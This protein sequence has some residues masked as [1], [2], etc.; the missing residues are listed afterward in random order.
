MSNSDHALPHNWR[1]SIAANGTPGTNSPVTTFTGT[2]DEDLD[3]SAF[4]EYA[5]GT[6]DNT[7]DSSP[8]ALNEGTLS[9]SRSLAAHDLRLIVE[10][11]TD[12][13]PG[14]IIEGESL[15]V[16]KSD[17]PAQPQVMT[18]FAT[19]LWSGN[20]QLWWIAGKKGATLTA[21]FIVPTAGDFNIHF[22]ATKAIDYGIH[23][24]TINGTSLGAA[25][26]FYQS[27]AK[28]VSHTG[29]VSLGKA[30]LKAGKN[31]L[32][33]TAAGTNPQAVKNYMFGLDFIRLAPA[34]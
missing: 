14:T 8:L 2:P 27:K 26:D 10:T 28:G 31:I 20:S 4:V 29:Q 5:L 21:E 25:H 15:R 11:S 1:P 23:S 24:F 32:T 19:G 12:L 16:I 18:S 13:G 22:A 34:K 17:G 6:D 33:I 9:F 3:L 7:F 30:K